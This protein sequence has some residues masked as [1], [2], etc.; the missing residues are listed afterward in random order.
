MCASILDASISRDS[1][2][3]SALPPAHAG[4]RIDKM[5]KLEAGLDN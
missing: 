1:C 4:N 3:R 2:E 5:S